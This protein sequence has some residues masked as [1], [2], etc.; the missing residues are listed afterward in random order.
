[1]NNLKNKIENMRFMRLF[2]FLKLILSIEKTDLDNLFKFINVLRNLRTNYHINDFSNIHEIYLQTNWNQRNINNLVNTSFSTLSNNTQRKVLRLNEYKV[3]SQNGEDGLILF[4]LSK[5]ENLSKTFIDIGCGGKT[6]NSLN[7]V[8]N[9]GYSGLYIDGDLES[10]NETKMKLEKCNNISQNCVAFSNTW[11]TK[12][13]VNKII[14]DYKI[15]NPNMDDLDLISIDVDGVDYWIFEALDLIKPKI[16]V[17][18]YNA[19]FGKELS[20][21]V[22]YDER[23][24][25]IN[26][27]PRKWYHGASLMALKNIG[28]IKGYS[29]IGCDSNGV[30]A[31]LLRDDV[32][33]ND[34]SE[35]N[36]EDAYY[37]HFQR[38][39]IMT[40]SEQISYLINN[41]SLFEI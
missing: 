21:T 40:L 8:L 18:E 15:S 32:I 16:V 20:V 23:F 37:E 31:I 10:I 7:L 29:L 13:N 22:P 5:I 26:H 12:E 35:I 14:Y 2:N 38:S 25:A 33:P 36:V 1:M 34:L 39:K 6:S 4:L 11:I 24:D 28:K 41:Y 17:I 9:Y 19:S 27:H 3:Y 30:N